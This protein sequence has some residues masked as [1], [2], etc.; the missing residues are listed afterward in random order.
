MTINDILKKAEVD[1]RAGAPA[2]LSDLYAVAARDDK[3]ADLVEAGNVATR[4]N[5]VLQRRR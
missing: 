4:I 3:Q 5:A 2:E 1:A